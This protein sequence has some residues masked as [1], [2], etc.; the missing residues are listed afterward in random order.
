MSWLSGKKTNKQICKQAEFTAQTKRQ[1]GSLS[2][3]F[4]VKKSEAGFA[5]TSFL[6]MPCV[7]RRRG[8][9]NWSTMRTERGFTVTLF[10]CLVWILGRKTKKRR[11]M[12]FR[13]K[14][15]HALHSHHAPWPRSD[16]FLLVWF[17]SHSLLRVLFS[18]N[19]Q[20][21]M[22]RSDTGVTHLLS[23]TTV[24]LRLGPSVCDRRGVDGVS[25]SM[26]PWADDGP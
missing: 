4:N 6:L 20:R 26:V 5:F 23:K 19:N 16:W 3:S 10:V 2:A 11:Q 12:T 15:F 18:S 1:Q 8:Y 22:R 21:E 14:V 25:L 7:H 13:T 24:S 17:L 9:R